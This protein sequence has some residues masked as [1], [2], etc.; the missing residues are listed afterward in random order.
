[1]H[2]GAG[3]GGGGGAGGDGGGGDGGSGDGGGGDGGSGDGGGGDGGVGDGGVGDDGVDDPPRCDTVTCCPL[4]MMEPSREVPL[5][6]DAALNAI[7]PLPLPDAGD[8][9]EIQ[10]TAVEASHA[11]SGSALT[12]KLPRPPPAS[13][14]DGDPNATSHLTALGAEET[15]ADD[16]PHPPI[17]TAATTTNRIATV[18]R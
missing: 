18:E 10:L 13:T 16:S 3:A 9:A 2:A 14:V 4:T 12:L 5:S 6:F 8:T 7:V 17:A 1:M 15:P 11:Q